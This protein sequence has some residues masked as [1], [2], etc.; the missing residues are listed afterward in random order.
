MLIDK[1]EEIQKIAHCLPDVFDLASIGDNSVGIETSGFNR[2]WVARDAFDILRHGRP[3]R[4]RVLG[5]DH[6]GSVLGLGERD[7]VVF[8]LDFP[9]CRRAHPMSS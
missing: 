1:P 7:K 8:R 4:L 6:A 5:T 3:F 2:Q 9:S